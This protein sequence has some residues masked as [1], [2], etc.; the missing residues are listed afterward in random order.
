MRRRVSM[1]LRNSRNFPFHIICFFI[2]SMFQIHPVFLPL[3]NS[4]GFNSGNLISWYLISFFFFFCLLQI[5]FF[6]F[7]LFLENLTILPCFADKQCWSIR[8]KCGSWWPKSCYKWSN[9]QLERNSN[10]ELWINGGR[11]ADKLLGCQENGWGLCSSSPIV[12][13]AKDSQC[14]ILHGE[15]KGIL[16]INIVHSVSI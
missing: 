14:F 7:F 9:S 1:L 5:K 11:L 13:I 16:Q 12:T 15:V 6:F 10:S 3:L 2:S 4:S 8:S